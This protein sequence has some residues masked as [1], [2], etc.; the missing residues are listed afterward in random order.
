VQGQHPESFIRSAAQPGNSGG[1]GNPHRPLQDQVRI[2]QLLEWLRM[3]IFYYIL[4]LY[5]HS[6]DKVYPSSVCRVS[7]MIY[8]Y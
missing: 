6:I 4:G 3:A 2:K 5:K 1:R 8:L 7:A